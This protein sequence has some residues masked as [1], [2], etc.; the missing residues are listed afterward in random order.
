M[1]KSVAIIL[2]VLASMALPVW[3][4]APESFS[5][6]SPLVGWAFFDLS[7]LNSSLQ[8]QGYPVLAQTLFIWGARNNFSSSGGL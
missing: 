7:G 3:G 6:T 4:Q 1:A 2:L 8:A 5:F